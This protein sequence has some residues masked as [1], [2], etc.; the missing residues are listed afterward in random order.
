MLRVDSTARAVVWRFLDRARAR[1]ETSAPPEAAR[2][3][4]L[5]LH[6]VFPRARESSI[7]ACSQMEGSGATQRERR[8]SNEIV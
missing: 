8:I 2:A 4:L 7:I 6:A 3:A 1:V 5:E